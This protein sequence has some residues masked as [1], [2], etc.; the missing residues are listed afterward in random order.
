MNTQ[1]HSLT[2]SLTR[3]LT[4]AVLLPASLSAQAAV[5]ASGQGAASARTSTAGRAATTTSS[6]TTSGHADVRIPAEYSAE[7]RARI[8]AVYARAEAQDVPR[9]PVE[10][11]VAE[12][13]AKGAAEATVVA[14]A[15]RVMAN[16]EASQSAMLA[17]GRKRPAPAEMER[18][19]HAMDRGVTAVQ[20]EAMARKAPS[21]RSLVVA[22]DVLTQLTA[23]GTPV[24]TALAQ[25]EG[26]LES[27]A[28]D[29]SLTS[30]ISIGGGSRTSGADRPGTG[31]IAG[32]GGAAA[33]GGA[34]VTG[35]AGAAGALGATGG[36]AGGVTGSA[37]GG[38]TGAV[39]TTV[40][41]VIGR[42]P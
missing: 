15:E 33:T 5:T 27:R 37:T 35:A 11:R 24:A 38:V 9:E 18:A 39:G 34:S 29:A 6:L 16:L 30:L 3:S 36:V 41:G 19:A 2:R 17:A 25:V 14:A 28:T 10:R 42:K 8:E 7:G 31:A 22:F 23:Q 12:G 40:G 13:R 21:E 26:K 32:S 20:I 4:V 1:A